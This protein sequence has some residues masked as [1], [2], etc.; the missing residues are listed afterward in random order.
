MV[1]VRITPTSF[2]AIKAGAD[3]TDG[4]EFLIVG[5]HAS[6]LLRRFPSNFRLIQFEEP[7]AL[8]LP[9]RI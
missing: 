6:R 5:I 1:S 8:F 2:S 3:A 7:R 9:S 4:H